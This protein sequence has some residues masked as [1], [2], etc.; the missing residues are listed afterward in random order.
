LEHVAAALACLVAGALVGWY[1]RGQTAA[2]TAREADFARQAARAHAVY[3]PEV[4]HPVE[5][6]ADQ[7]Q[8]LINWLSKRLGG[9]IKVP[10]LLDLGYE[11]VGGRL[12]PGE[13]GPV[14][15]FMYQEGSGRRLT[16]YI[17][18]DPGSERETAFRYLQQGKVA[19]FYWLDR[20]LSYALSGEMP[21][22]DLLKIANVIYQRLN[23]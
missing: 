14:A 8:H 7:E 17:R 6:T 10:P 11:L 2:V 21:K 22:E 16:L 19:V 3:T 5:V 18:T 23:P 13:R 12:L 9:P 15:Q 20:R 1:L 4:R